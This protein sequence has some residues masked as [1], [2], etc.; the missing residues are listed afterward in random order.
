MTRS[1]R[2]EEMSDWGAKTAGCPFKNSSP[3]SFGMASTSGYRIRQHGFRAEIR[4]LYFSSQ[5]ACP[6]GGNM[7]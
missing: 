5:K 6:D 1:W 7:R 3:G 2:Q 4:D